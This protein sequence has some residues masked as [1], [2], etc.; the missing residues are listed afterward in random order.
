MVKKEF[1][2]AAELIDH[3]DVKEHLKESPADSIGAIRTVPLKT[4]KIYIHVYQ[5]LLWNK[6]AELLLNTGT[7]KNK[8]V[9]IIGLKK[10]IENLY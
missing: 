8:K 3:K 10:E 5:S 2:K 4:R 6:A 7:T 1:N 9:P